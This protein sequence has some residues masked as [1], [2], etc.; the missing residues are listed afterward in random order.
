MASQGSL[1]ILWEDCVAVIP[2][3]DGLHCR[4]GREGSRLE[5]VLR[6]WRRVSGIIV[7]S[8]K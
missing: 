4:E 8:N 6:V 2:S 1:N 5:G 3:F 7:K